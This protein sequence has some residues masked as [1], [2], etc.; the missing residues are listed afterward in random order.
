MANTSLNII[1]L[2]VS[3]VFVRINPIRLLSVRIVTT[4]Q[5]LIKL[6]EYSFDV[7]KVRLVILLSYLPIFFLGSLYA[8][9]AARVRCTKREATTN[10]NIVIVIVIKCAYISNKIIP[11]AGKII[12][13]ILTC[14]DFVEGIQ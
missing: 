2:S 11:T 10:D 7:Q 13:K 3:Y 8:I 6:Y 4:G 1:D 9:S 14:V 12:Q 5:A